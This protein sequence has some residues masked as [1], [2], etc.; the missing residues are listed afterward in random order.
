MTEITL[1]D[2]GKGQELIARSGKPAAPRWGTQVMIDMPGLVAD[3]HA[4]YADAGATLATTNTYLIHR[5]RLRGGSDNYYAS[6]DT[7]LDDIEDQFLS[8]LDAALEETK[9][10]RARSRIAGSVGPLGASYRNNST[11]AKGPT[12]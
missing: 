7:Q 5:D 11:R 8:L 3:V 10:V 1:L 6:Q 12:S 9:D 2:G 4:A